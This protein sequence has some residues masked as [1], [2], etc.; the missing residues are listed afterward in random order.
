MYPSIF[1]CAKG[2]KKSVLYVI[3]ELIYQ[4]HSLSLPHDEL[5]EMN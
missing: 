1:L 5:C 4:S 2:L 3:S